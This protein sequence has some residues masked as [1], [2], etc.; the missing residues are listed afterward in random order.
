M[1]PERILIPIDVAKCPLEVFNVVNGFVERPGVTVILLHV[2]NLNIAAPENRVYAELGREADAHLK[3][4]AEICVNPRAS[5]L[6][7]VRFGKPAQEIVAAAKEENVDL[8]ILPRYRGSFW[9]RIFA[10]FAPQIVQKV[11][12]EAPCGVCLVTVKT[13]FNCSK[14]WSWARE[15]AI[16]ADFVAGIT[17]KKN[18]RAFVG[19]E[20]LPTH[21]LSQ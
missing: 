11:I 2:V 21:L 4:L 15:V 10:F 14:E 5:I 18:Y 9:K 19:K 16:A 8:I 17:E 3:R 12:R 6:T 1:K 20:L 7:R 13:R